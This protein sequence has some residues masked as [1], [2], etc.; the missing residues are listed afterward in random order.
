[1]INEPTFVYDNLTEYGT[2][3][4]GSVITIMN[5]WDIDKTD[6]PRVAGPDLPYDIL[7]IVYIKAF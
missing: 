3:Q 4:K 5:H 2:H 1:M 6:E 7:P